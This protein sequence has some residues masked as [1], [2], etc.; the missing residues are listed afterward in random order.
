[1][2]YLGRYQ[3]GSTVG[4]YL[5]TVDGSGVPAEPADTPY[6]IVWNG[7]T[8]VLRAGIAII[9]REAVPGYF[10]KQLFLNSDFAAGNYMVDL[11]WV[12]SGG[13]QGME[14]RY[15]EIV[16]GGHADGSVVAAYWYN[17]PH[18]SCLVHQSESG[19]LLPG[20]NPRL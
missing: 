7:S 6:A 10:F 12:M 4:I 9:E 17:R 16:P 14:Q 18:V 3:L 13:Y 5:R 20:K 15:F 1:M 8:E 2:I 19:N 11:R